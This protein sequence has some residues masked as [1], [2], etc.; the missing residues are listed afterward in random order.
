MEAR[1]ANQ[2][3][4]DQLPGDRRPD[5]QAREARPAPRVFV[6]SGHMIDEPQRQEARF[7]RAKEPIIRALIAQQ[8]A[9]WRVGA[10]DICLSGA[11]RGADI[12]FAEECVARGAVVRLLVALPEAEFLERSVRVAGGDDEARYR[13]LREHCATFFQQQELGSAP[14]DTDVFSRNNTWLIDAALALAPPQNIYALLVWDEKPTGDGPGGT[15]DFMAR[16]AAAGGQVAI[17]NPT[18]V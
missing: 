9:Q 17:I 12:L 6:C 13:R 2:L 16:V 11:A 1:L 8:L 7:P 14:Q 18:R 15:S 5:T 10:Q 3:P 4:A